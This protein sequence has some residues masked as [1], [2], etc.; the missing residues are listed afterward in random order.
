[1]ESLSAKDFQI[2]REKARAFCGTVKIPIDKLQHEELPDNPR[3][4]DEENVARLL[5]V[6]HKEGCYRRE[7]DNHVPALISRSGLPEGLIGA[8]DDLQLFNPDR[9]LIYLHGRHRLEAGR[10]FLTGNDR[11]WVVDLYSD[12]ELFRLLRQSPS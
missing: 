4:F 1:M 7:S 8:D 9:S 2:F 10:R 6:F 11:W 12:G 3:Q 5:D